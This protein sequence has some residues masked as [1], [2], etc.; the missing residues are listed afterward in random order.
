MRYSDGH[1]NYWG[2]IYCRA[3]LLDYDLPFALRDFRESG[4]AFLP[5]TKQFGAMP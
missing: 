1:L 3:N 4:Q 5:L 2:E